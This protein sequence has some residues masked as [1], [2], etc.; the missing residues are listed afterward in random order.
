M[1]EYIYKHI[2]KIYHFLT[3]FML[4]NLISHINLI[5]AI[6]VTL[7]LSIYKEIRDSKQPNNY[8][9]IKDLIAD[10]LGML[11]GIIHIL[12]I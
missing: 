7:A 3:T 4:V 9:D 11:L 10:I 2:D 8:F 5:L 6:L 12:L 1:F